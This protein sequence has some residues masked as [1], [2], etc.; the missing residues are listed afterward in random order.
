MRSII[1]DFDGTIAD[2]FSEIVQVTH[3]LTHAPQ[4]SNVEEVKWLRDHDHGL[5]DA[6]KGL[7]IP[8]WQLPWLLARGRRMLAK[9][10]HQVPLY[11][12][13]A[14]VFKK[15]NEEKYEMYI[16]SSNSAHNVERFMLEKGILTYFKGVYGSIGLFDKTTALKRIIKKA[17]LDPAATIYVGDE[18][19]DIQATKAL[20]MPC[21][22]VTWGFNSENLL[23][24][25]SPMVIAHTPAQ[26]QT[27]LIEWGNTL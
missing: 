10:I 25:Q 22:A 6:L 18:V 16:I 1:W 13:L 14:E 12:G 21:V 8:K 19:R 27:I 20:N 23:Y 11:P 4:L 15:L 17:H 9:R 2:S 24:E 26:L 7:K 3:E 5:V